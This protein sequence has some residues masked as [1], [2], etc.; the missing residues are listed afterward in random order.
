M[1][2]LALAF[3]RV[4]LAGLAWLVI[5]LAYWRIRIRNTDHAEFTGQ[6]AGRESPS[7]TNLTAAAF[8]T[9]SWREISNTRIV[10]CSA[11]IAISAHV[12]TNTAGNLIEPPIMLLWISSAVLWGFVFSPLKWN[13]FS[14]ARGRIIA[15]HNFREW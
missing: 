4:V 2:L 13:V 1:D 15:W 5:E 12:W 6:I 7:E 9:R 8:T 10:L 3:D 14:W 11:A